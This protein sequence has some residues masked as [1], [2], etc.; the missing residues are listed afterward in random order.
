MNFSLTNLL[1]GVENEA[2][3]VDLEP[4]MALIVPPKWWHYV[5]TLEFSLNFN[6]WIQLVSKRG[7]I[8]SIVGKADI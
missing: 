8:S 7:S 6:T 3:H 2:F 4:G 1:P 5:E